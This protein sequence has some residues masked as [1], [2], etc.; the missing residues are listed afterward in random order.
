MADDPSTSVVF[1]ELSRPNPAFFLA[2]QALQSSQQAVVC[3]TEVQRIMED[4]HIA[5]GVL[6]ERYDRPFEWKVGCARYVFTQC[7]LLD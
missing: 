3:M 5:A 2:Q 1:D 6:I 4:T 7:F